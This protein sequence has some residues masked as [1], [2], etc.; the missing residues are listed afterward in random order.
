MLTHPGINHHRSRSRW[1]WL[2]SGGLLLGA[3]LTG[4]GAQVPTAIRPDGTLGTTVRQHG[5]RYDITGGTRP[6]N[7]P[8]LFHSF[9]QFSVGTRD[10]AR[11][12]GPAEIENI[13]SRVTG[14]QQSVID[15]RVQTTIPGANVYFLNPAGVV[16]GPHA[17]LDVQGSLH[18]S[19]AD[20]LRLADTATFSAHLGAHSTLTVAPPAAFGFLR[21]APAPLTVQ[22]S[23]LAV[24][25]GK[26]LS[27]VGGDVAVTGGML[28]TPSGRLTLAGMGEPG[29]VPVH[30]AMH[31]PALRPG[32]GQ[33]LGTISLARGALLTTTDAPGGTVTIRGGRFV[34]TENAQI[35]A[36]AAGR[37][38]GAYA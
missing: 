10:T 23:T 15:G 19:T 1:V 35:L 11:F 7:G 9:E 18:V 2:L 30:R 24:P 6:Q 5:T 25:P 21:P 16:F 31:A 20:Y 3:L 8:N 37:P 32:S 36:N 34:M 14:N 29:E 28:S 33:R 38:E 22:G 27:L 4:S 13:L 12:R 26:A 17:T